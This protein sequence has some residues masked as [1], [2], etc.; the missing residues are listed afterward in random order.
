MA[1]Q[2]VDPAGFRASVD[3]R[4]RVYARST[5]VPNLV[6]RR[7]AALERLMVRLM[8]VAP[9]RWALKGGLA[10][11][12]RLRGR[13][14]ASMDMD[15]DHAQGRDAAREDLAEAHRLVTT[16]LAPILAG[17]AQGRWDPKLGVWS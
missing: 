17:S 4:L 7:Q 14:R 8:I 1:R 16:W 15:I 11:E 5:G 10:L 13:A 12:T 6:V 3:Q 2:F 9:G